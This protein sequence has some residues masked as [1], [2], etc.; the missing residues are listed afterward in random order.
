MVANCLEVEKN[1]LW[2]NSPGHKSD[3]GIGP[4]EGHL[5]PTSTGFL[6]SSLGWPSGETPVA[7]PRGNTA[8]SSSRFP[9]LC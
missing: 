4:G 2:Q 6:G 3:Q 8:A 5:G 7:A 9:F 1:A